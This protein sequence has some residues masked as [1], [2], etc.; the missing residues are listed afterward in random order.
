M[1][2]LSQAENAQGIAD[3]FLADPD[4]YAPYLA[5]IENVMTRDSALS[6]AEREMIAAYVSRLN[7][8]DFCLG[9]HAWTLAAMDISPAIIDCVTTATDS[10]AIDGRLRPVLDFARKLTERPG[11]IGQKDIDRLRG[12]GWSDEAIEDAINVIALFNAVNR[13]VDAF[14]IEGNEDYFRMI[15][16]A[17]AKQGYAPLRQAVLK[18]AS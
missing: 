1:P 11:E 5:F 18:Q 16:K 14:G 6:A 2:Y 13:L 3:V 7:D 17:L 12:A 10:E 4:R 9:A 15:G 8:C